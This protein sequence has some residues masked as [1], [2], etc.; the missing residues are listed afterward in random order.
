MKTASPKVSFLKFKDIERPVHSIIHI[1]WI[2]VDLWNR[3]KT[4]YMHWC[5]YIHHQKTITENSIWRRRLSV[6]SCSAEINSSCF[7]CLILS[8]YVQQNS[9]RVQYTRERFQSHLVYFADWFPQRTRCR[10]VDAK[11]PNCDANKDTYITN[12]NYQLLRI[13]DFIRKKI[14][15][16][17]Q[18][19][20]A[21]GNQRSKT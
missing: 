9:V 20:T 16:N 1:F 6:I 19:Q 17:T 5:M 15:Q 4:R 18:T 10:M 13:R 3:W 12:S 7:S 8:Q 11:T 21:Q 14:Q 2:F